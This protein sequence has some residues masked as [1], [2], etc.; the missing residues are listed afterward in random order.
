[1]TK[2]LRSAKVWLGLSILAMAVPMA[3]QQQPPAVPGQPP[4]AAPAAQQPAPPAAPATPAPATPATPRPQPDRYVVGQA[5]PVPPAGSQLVDMTLEQATDMA[6]EKNLDLKAAKLSPQAV[7]YQLQA[8]RAAFN[9]RFTGTYG[10]NNQSSPNNSTILDPTLSRITQQSQTFN[11]GASQ[12]LGWHGAAYTATFNN[13]RTQSNSLQTQF[14]PNFSS[15][16][17]ATFSLPLLAGFK[18]DQTRNSLKTTTIQRQI[19]DIQL[20]TTIENLKA[21]V[22]TAYWNLRQAIEQI[23]INQRALDLANRLFEDNKVKV[24]IGT[25]APIDTVQSEANVATAEQQLLQARISWQQAELALKRLLVSG[26]EDDL[27]KAT[28]NPTEQASLSV[29]GVD[30]PGAIQ[31]ALA[32]R[33]DL[34]QARKNIE[35]SK[36]GLELTKDQTKPQLD[37]SSTYRLQ[38][39]GGQRLVAGQ[40][41]PG[42]YSDALAQLGNIV[43][44]TWSMNFN[45]SYPL[46]MAAAKANYARASIQLDQSLAQLKA[47]ELTVQQSV[48]TAGLAVENTYKQY[49][50]AQKAREAQEHNAE[51]QQTR[52]DVGM[53]TNYEVVQAQQALTNARLSELRSII[54]YMN[55]VAEFDRVQRV[56]GNGG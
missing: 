12:T 13:G 28:I 7:D 52:F 37:F 26:P 2:F 39:Q 42:G 41:T 9:P 32:E 23:E 14:N 40:R 1:M 50:A 55:A 48:T 6:L 56:G 29:Q 17:S 49:Q 33:T 16:L 36:I 35:S 43:N 34:V 19:A 5:R 45:F 44:P 22:R 51:A 54:N 10:Y 25:L 27:Y 47:Q 4:S 18:T 8:A 21:S 46:G 38:G 24:E 15:N 30:I 3:A 53:S 31:S 11:M 20:Q